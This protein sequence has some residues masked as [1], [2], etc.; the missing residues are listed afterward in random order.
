MGVDSYAEIFTLTLGWHFYNVIWDVITATGIVYLPFLGILIE[1]WREAF[2]TGEEGNGAAKAV[3]SME[4]DIYLAL[5]VVLLACVP[6]SLTPLDRSA[7]FYSPPASTA[8]PTPTTATGVAPASTFTSFSG[9]P[10]VVN[11]PVWWYSVLALSSGIT[12][13]TISGS[14]LSLDGLRQIA[15]QGKRATIDNPQVRQ[16]VQRF[17]NECFVPAR[18]AFLSS[19]ASPAATAAIANYGAD[20]PDWMG[21]HTFRDDPA[22]YGSAYAS[23]S[24]TGWAFNPARDKDLASSPTP[25]TWGRPSCK[26]WWEDS[27]IG[28]RQKLIAEAAANSKLPNLV[29]TFGGGM[30]LEQRADAIVKA[31][32]DKTRLQVMPDPYSPD[33]KGFWATAADIPKSAA[34]EIGALIV[35][36]L[37]W[38]AMAIIR[39]SLP[40]VQAIVLMG[41]CI[42]LP[43][44]MVLSRYSLEAMV[45][46]A[47]TIFTV[48][49]WSVMW[50]IT[51]YLDDKLILAMYP[52]AG[53]LISVLTSF[54][55]KGDDTKAILLNLVV[56]S[57]YIGLPMLWTGMMAMVGIHL[58]HAIGEPM[59]NSMERIQLASKETSNMASRAFVKAGRAALKK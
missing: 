33:N 26:E 19:P 18:T 48:K 30:T 29:A 8:N 16:E 31:T 54:F 37:T 6:S 59:T 22:L 50:F 2:I 49:F 21:S 46:G 20:D 10:A 25:P 17:H 51:D 45:L 3:R 58:R 35:G 15:E 24:V 36:A 41:I 13:A 12:H 7:L 53:G 4:M 38:F 42:F 40:F 11:V 44:V 23:T 14:T 34:S 57:L 39:P 47:L 32:I 52:D 5:T 9:T 1:H 56:V 55:G 43:L 28:L 27:T